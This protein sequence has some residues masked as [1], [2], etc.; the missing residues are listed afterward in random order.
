MLVGI[1]VVLAIMMIVLVVLWTLHRRKRK[2]YYQDL[3]LK[4][5][6]VC[7]GRFPSIHNHSTQKELVENFDREKLVRIDSFLDEPSLQSLKQEGLA[8]VERGIRNFVP[9]HKKGRSLPYERLHLFAPSCLAFYHSPDVQQWIGNIVGT[10][11]YPAGDHDQSACSVLFY[12]Q[13][14]DHINWHYDH[15]YYYGRQFT[16]LL[17][18][19]NKSKDGGVSASNYLR[20]LPNGEAGSV[21]T[22]ENTLVVFEGAK[23]LHKVTPTEPGDLRIVLSMTYNT[24]PR[25]NWFYEFIR[26]I[27]DTA[28]HGLKALWD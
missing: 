5:K 6:D 26:R 17:S 16:V 14:G 4:R 24:D 7:Q 18:L 20:K 2:R 8:N 1:G 19:I 28:F 13:P 23:V 22:S 10:R 15:N 25:I 9:L 11:V 21:D 12:D 3:A 27:K